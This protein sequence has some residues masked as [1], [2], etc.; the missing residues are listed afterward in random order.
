[1]L[2]SEKTDLLLPALLVA[3]SH[4][5]PAGKDKRNEHFRYDYATEQSWHDAVQPALLD[6]DLLLTFSITGSERV[7]NLTTVRGT[8][9]VTHASGQWLEVGGVGEGMDNADKAAYKAMT[10]FKKYC[11]ALCFALPTTDDA[12][13]DSHDRAR[14][15]AVSFKATKEE[16]VQSQAVVNAQ[17]V[18]AGKEPVTNPAEKEAAAAAYK[19]LNAVAPA[20]AKAIKHKHGTGYF[21]MKIELDVAYREE[22]ERTCQ[23]LVV[24]GA[25]Q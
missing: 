4:M 23:E 14:V 11:Y 12:E 1:M 17:L 25:A 10:G 20:R 21:D 15:K 19:L 6:R 8:A 2:T 9:R 5:Q 24:D 13:D 18:A 22:L 7:G 3:R 16:K